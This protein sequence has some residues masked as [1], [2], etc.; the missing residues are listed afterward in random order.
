MKFEPM[1]VLYALCNLVETPDD[2]LPF[3]SKA[4]SGSSRQHR[5]PSSTRGFAQ[6]RVP[7]QSLILGL[8]KRSQHTEIQKKNTVTAWEKA[9]TNKSGCAK[10]D[11]R[12]FKK[13]G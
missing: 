1:K 9:Q 12:L 8:E 3:R 11:V 6:S 7:H 2:F 5:H 13:Q 10:E 4:A